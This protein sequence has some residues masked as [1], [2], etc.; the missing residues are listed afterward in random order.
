[1]L[2]CLDGDKLTWAYYQGI[3]DFTYID[4]MYVLPTIGT[5]QVARKRRVVSI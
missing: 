2:I 1:M 4:C 5:Y 3:T